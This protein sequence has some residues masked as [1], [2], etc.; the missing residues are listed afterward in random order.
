MMIKSGSPLPVGSVASQSTKC[1]RGGAAGLTTIALTIA[2]IRVADIETI[3]TL[4]FEMVD[5]YGEARAGGI[6]FKSLRQ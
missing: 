1:F 4:G 3:G 2:K 5:D 6:D